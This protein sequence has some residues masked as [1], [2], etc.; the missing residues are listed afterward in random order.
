MKDTMLHII[1]FLSDFIL[2]FLVFSYANINSDKPPF[3]YKK[4]SKVFSYH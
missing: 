3:P 4:T 2:Y 1:S